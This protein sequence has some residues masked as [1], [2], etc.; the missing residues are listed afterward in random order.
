MR[1]IGPNATAVANSP[2]AARRAANS[3]GFSLP[4]EEQTS[5]AAV[6]TPTLRSVGGIDAL[7]ALQSDGEIGERRKRAVKRGRIALDALDELKHG[8][9]AGTLSPSTLLRL[10]S[11]ATE[12]RD[13]SGEPAL[14]TVLSEIALRV[15]V[16]IAKFSPP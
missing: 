6:G 9:L 11:A 16:E 13:S 15:E 2:K 4:A 7:I 1:I 8:L 3:T 5:S 14:D 10:K 12:L